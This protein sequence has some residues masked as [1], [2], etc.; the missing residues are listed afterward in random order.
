MTHP[1]ITIEDVLGCVA[2]FAIAF[3]GQFLGGL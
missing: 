3:G 2:L 1:K